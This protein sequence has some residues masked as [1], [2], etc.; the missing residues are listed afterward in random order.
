MAVI[1]PYT[2]TNL[3]GMGS[4]AQLVVLDF[5]N[6]LRTSSS[7]TTANVSKLAHTP[8]SLNGMYGA[9][10]TP[11]SVRI[12]SILSFKSCQISLQGFPQN[13]DQVVEYFAS[14]HTGCL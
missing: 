8:S 6:N 9:S 1:P 5:I 11:M 2:L 4:R 13:H 12:A 7:E 10:V 14:Y 3:V